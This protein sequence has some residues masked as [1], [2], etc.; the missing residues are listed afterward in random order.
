MKS[1]ALMLK[2]KEQKIGIYCQNIFDIQRHS[3]VSNTNCDNI[4][5]KKTVIKFTIITLKVCILYNYV[6]HYYLYDCIITTI[7]IV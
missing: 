5:R 3:L 1:A 2:Y 7:I 6:R 4:Y